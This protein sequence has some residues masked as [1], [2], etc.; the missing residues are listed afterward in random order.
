LIEVPEAEIIKGPNRP[1]VI[2]W[3]NQTSLCNP[4]ESFARPNWIRL[5]TAGSAA[6]H[7]T[8]TLIKNWHKQ[9]E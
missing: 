8:D 2:V 3:D 5:L 7:N 4:A 6:I 9:N 1:F